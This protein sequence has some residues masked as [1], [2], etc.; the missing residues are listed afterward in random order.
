M[1]QAVSFI[2]INEFDSAIRILKD[3]VK[4]KGSNFHAWYYL[5]LAYHYSHNY[6]ERL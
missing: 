3:C 6:R 4:R 1:R 5:G 2:M